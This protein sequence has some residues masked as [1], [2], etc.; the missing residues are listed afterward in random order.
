[1]PHSET[2]WNRKMEHSKRF[3]YEI[4]L[5]RSLKRKTRNSYA[6]NFRRKFT[7]VRNS[8]FFSTQWASRKSIWII[9]SIIIIIIV[10]V[11]SFRNF[12]NSKRDTMVHFRERISSLVPFYWRDSNTFTTRTHA[13][14]STRH[15]RGCSHREVC[16]RSKLTPLH[17]PISIRNRRPVTTTR[18]FASG[19]KLHAIWLEALLYSSGIER[20]ALIR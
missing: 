2:M 20:I 4:M 17:S 10:V 12:I 7:C 14:I 6:R 16:S 3:S 8:R 19:Y 11:I 5:D 15:F 18:R 1:M 13:C 9:T